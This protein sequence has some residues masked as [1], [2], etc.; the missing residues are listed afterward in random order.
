MCEPDAAK[1]AKQPRSKNTAEDK[2]TYTDESGTPLF[3][4]RRASGK[5]FTQWSPD[6]RGGW[7]PGRHGARYVLYR[8]PDV[9]RHVNSGTP[10]YVVEGEKDADRAWAHGIPATTNPGGAGKWRD[11]YSKIL[12]NSAV[13]VVFDRDA[14]G[15]KHALEVATSIDQAGGPVR[16]A[17][18]RVGKDLSD[19]LDAGYG[20]ADLAY[21]RPKAP[22]PKP[23]TVPVAAGE[24]SR[25]CTSLL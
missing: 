11:E 16:F 12:R 2:Y 7:R 13:V 15:R 23:P 4:V 6:G 14:A 22:K 3:Q 24:S 17:H 19:H 25:R 20:V 8:L 10:F 1:T 21:R 18:A 5:Q 9:I